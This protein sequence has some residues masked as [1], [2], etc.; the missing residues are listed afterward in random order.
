M[1]AKEK[2]QI[3]LVP[4]LIKRGV[5]NVVVPPYTPLIIDNVIRVLNK[6][7]EDH[8]YAITKYRGE[9]IPQGEYQK[10]FQ[11]FQA[12]T[13]TEDEI[14]GT[15]RDAKKKFNVLQE[16]ICMFIEEKS[17]IDSIWRDPGM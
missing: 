16:C 12:L 17:E 11:Q 6:T 1:S 14:N 3:D 2:I 9:T 5:K 4:I 10:L 7:L 8:K 15:L 13:I